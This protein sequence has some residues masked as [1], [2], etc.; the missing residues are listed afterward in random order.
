MR[1][2]DPNKYHVNDLVAIKRVQLGPGL[3]L[4]PKYLRPCRITKVKPHESYDVVKAG[5]Y[6]GP[7][8]ITTCAEYLKWW[9][10]WNS[11]DGVSSGANDNAG[12]PNCRGSTENG[13]VSED[14]RE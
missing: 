12:G 4:K 13:G 14:A 8:K 2:R 1:H 11:G 6:E 9:I 10:D 7:A 3:K 5:G